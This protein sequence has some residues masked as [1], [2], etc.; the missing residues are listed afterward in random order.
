MNIAGP[1]MTS[2]D[3]VEEWQTEWKGSSH[4]RHLR[5]LLPELSP[6]TINL[7]DNLTPAERSVLLQMRTGKIGLN[8]FLATVR[9]AE[10]NQCPWTPCSNMRFG[11]RP[12]RKA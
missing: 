12:S 7:Y 10:S 2:G 8:S 9:Q 11:T 3:G 5:E 4:G 6:K 1:S